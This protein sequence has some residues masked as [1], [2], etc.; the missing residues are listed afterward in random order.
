MAQVLT[1]I[2]KPWPN[3]LGI[4]LR[5]H[6]DWYSNLSDT[7]TRPSRDDEVDRALALRARGGD[8][9]AVRRLVERHQAMVLRLCERM[10]GNRHDA[11]DVVQESFVRALRS[12]AKWDS[13]RALRP[14]LLAIA[15]NRCRTALTKR[16]PLPCD[17][18]VLAD[19]LPARRDG[20]QR[21]KQL[22]EEV[23]LALADLRPEYRQAFEL[24]HYE[25]L[26]YAEIAEVLSVPVGTVKTWIHRAR[27]ETATRLIRRGVVEK[28]E[29]RAERSENQHELP[30][31]PRA[32]ASLTG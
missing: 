22:T 25:Q 20:S 5:P 9:S 10:L 4:F 19:E 12:L 3:S 8:Q 28:V 15:A 6:C 26:A 11:E 27:Q 31:I 32:A 29:A 2:L 13:T 14:W 18:Q 17:Q 1:K 24:F 7:D 21:L 23:E 16:K 30:A